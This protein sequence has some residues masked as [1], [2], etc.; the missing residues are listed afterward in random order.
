MALDFELLAREFL[1]GLRGR[2]SQ[3]GLSRRLGYRTNVVYAWESGRRWPTAATVFRA[4][5]TLRFD[6]GALLNRFF[7]SPPPWLSEV[8]LASQDGVARVLQELRGNIQIG[9][10]ARRSGRSRYALSRWLNGQAEP[11]F[12]DFLRVFEAASLRLLDFIALFIDPR[13]LSAAAR[14]WKLLEA[15]RRAC[16]ELPWVPAVLRA[17][18][19]ADYLRLPAHEP[20]WIAKRLGVSREEEERCLDALRESGQIRLHRRR[21]EPAPDLTVDTRSD[22]DAER[23]LKQYW[24]EVGIARLSAGSP[25]LFSFNVFAVSEADLEKLR[26]LHRS[27]FRKLRSIIAQSS[28]SERIAVANVQLFSLDLAMSGRA[29]HGIGSAAAFAEKKRRAPTSPP[30]RSSPIRRPSGR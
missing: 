14:A 3:T 7:A 16:Y 30:G 21:F 13:E 27:Y 4:L 19:L 20:G 26:E 8:N 28:P 6:L 5:R 29:S 17:L 25:D 1:R 10:L 11:R 15:H 18:E 2:R 23:K 12:P 24:A 22:P 9:E